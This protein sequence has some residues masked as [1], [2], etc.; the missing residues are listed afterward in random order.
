[1]YPQSGYGDRAAGV[2]C[3]HLHDP[4]WLFR[5][6]PAWWEGRVQPPSSVPLPRADLTGTSFRLPRY[7]QILALRRSPAAIGPR[8]TG[9]NGMRAL[10]W[11]GKKDIRCDTV[12]DPQI[13]AAARRDHQGHELRDLRLRPAPLRRLHAR[14]GVRRHHGPRV[15]GRGGRGRAG[16]PASSRSATASSCRSRSSAASASSAGAATSRSASAPT[17]TRTWPTRSSA[18]PRPACSATPT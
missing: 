2:R 14:H 18:T 8:I 4:S 17:A 1:M 3:R 16:E 15:H 10:C 13:E 12:P 11:H 5:S 9:E 7:R 6:E